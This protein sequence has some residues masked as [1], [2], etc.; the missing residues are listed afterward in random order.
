MSN[1]DDVD[2]GKGLLDDCT[3]CHEPF[4]LSDVPYRTRCLHAFHLNCI[5]SWIQIRHT[6]PDCRAAVNGV[7]EI[8]K[9]FMLVSVIES[10]ARLK[11]RDKLGKNNNNNN[12]NSSNDNKENIESDKKPAVNEEQQ[13]E[14][15]D[16]ILNQ[17]QPSVDNYSPLSSPSSN[18]LDSS[19]GIGLERSSIVSGEKL[20]S[21]VPSHSFSLSH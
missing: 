18:T 13:Q 14:N 6:C 7:H 15:S 10:I 21:S 2:I 1:D 5:N 8:A 20:L 9:D 4:S 19:G 11:M 3:I 12:N 17:Q 16:S